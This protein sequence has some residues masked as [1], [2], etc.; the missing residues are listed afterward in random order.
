MDFSA[1]HHFCQPGVCKTQDNEQLQTDNVWCIPSL[2]TACASFSVSSLAFFRLASTFEGELFMLQ[3]LIKLSRITGI[4]HDWFLA[5]TLKYDF[6]KIRARIIEFSELPS[7]TNYM[8]HIEKHLRWV[9]KL[10]CAKTLWKTSKMYPIIL[11]SI[12]TSWW[13]AHIYS[14]Q[15]NSAGNWEWWWYWW[16]E[17]A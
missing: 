9:Y 14:L 11:C 7:R 12:S 6:H 8:S 10:S 1:A 3:I 2:F 15:S 5:T 4:I 16:Q 13:K 17:V